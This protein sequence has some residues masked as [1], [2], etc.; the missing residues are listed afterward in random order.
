MNA[1]ILLTDAIR[2]GAQIA[3]SAVATGLSRRGWD[4]TFVSMKPP[5]PVPEALTSAGLCVM[6][7]DMRSTL[8]MPRG[9][10]RLRRL[11]KRSDARVLQTA[12]WHANV[13]GRLAA[14]GTGVPVVSCHQ[15]VDDVKSRVRVWVDRTTAGLDALHVT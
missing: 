12:L 5:G 1:V 10:L 3:M 9:V 7:L 2:G 8:D 14:I 15:S 13:F 6:S 11:L 4:V